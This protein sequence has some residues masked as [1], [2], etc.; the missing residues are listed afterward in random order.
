MTRTRGAPQRLNPQR[1]AV[2]GAWRRV[3]AWRG[4][5]YGQVTVEVADAS[6]HG[7]DRTAR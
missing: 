7:A 4:P 3:A 2:H 5:Q 1:Y 6:P